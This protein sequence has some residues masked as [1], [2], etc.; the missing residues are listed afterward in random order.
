MARK[1]S[2]KGRLVKWLTENREDL[3]EG[4][5]EMFSIPRSERGDDWEEHRERIRER[6]ATL[7]YVTMKVKRMKH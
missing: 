4:L 7:A 1:L 3:Q 5:E 6:I 2:F